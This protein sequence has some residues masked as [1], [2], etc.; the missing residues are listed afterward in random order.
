MRKMTKTTESG[1]T[2]LEIVEHIIIKNL[3]EYYVTT[4]RHSDD[5]VRCLVMGFETELGDVSMEEIKPYIITRTSDLDEVMPAPGF[6]WV[7]NE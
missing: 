1:T 6:E 4:D 5:I 3:W 2:T 7:D